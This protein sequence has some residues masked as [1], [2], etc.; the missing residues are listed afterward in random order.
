MALD[1]K[2]VVRIANDLSISMSQDRLVGQLHGRDIALNDYALIALNTFR[3][4]TVYAD[5]IKAME[6][7]VRTPHEWM[8]ATREVNQMLSNGM[9]VGNM[10]PPLQEI[11]N[12]PPR[13][14][15]LKLHLDLLKD[16]E[17]TRVY[18]E[19]LRANIKPDDVVIDIGT[20]SG[21]LAMGAVLAGAKHVYAIEVGPIFETVRKVFAANGMSDR[22]T[23]LDGWSLVTDL[24]EQADIVVSEL[25]S[26]DVFIENILQVSSDAMR[27][28]LKPG[29]RL[30]P[31]R[32]KMGAR[33][34]HVSPEFRSRRV[35][36]KSDIAD[37]QSQ[38]HMN[39]E[40]LYDSQWQGQLFHYARLEE[41]NES[42]MMSDPVIVADVRLDAVESLEI[43]T[44]TT[45][46]TTRS[47]M[48]DGIATYFELE[49][50]PGHEMTTDPYAAVRADSWLQPIWFT[51]PVQVGEGDPFTIHFQHLHR[52][53][54][55]VELTLERLPSAD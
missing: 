46:R 44:A 32:V 47:G 41:L 49:V 16:R 3:T 40:P 5:G 25:L 15:E 48:V 4:P 7:Y 29:G 50:A 30:M 37:W 36:E 31:S 1:P 13:S 21:V 39:F 24:P 51:E 54:L 8:L 6:K 52:Y 42:T 10:E 55:A 14:I 9:L 45:V 11:R 12:R 27:R 53:P 22:I 20:G 23:L 18:L 17:R 38:Y 2:M 34:I 26:N 43:Q 19:A 33:L 35:I 28:F